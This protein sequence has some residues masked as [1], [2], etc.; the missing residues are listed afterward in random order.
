[1]RTP[2]TPLR[3]IG[4][5]EG[6]TLEMLMT[7]PTYVITWGN[8]MSGMVVYSYPSAA[9]AHEALNKAVA[10]IDK[11]AYIITR[12]EDISFNGRLLVDVFNRLTESGVN[13]FASR[14]VGTRRLYSVLST[15]AQP[16][17]QPEESKMNDEYE[18]NQSE[19]ALLPE[20]FGETTP[21][22]ADG[23]SVR[24]EEGTK[25]PRSKKAAPATQPEEKAKRVQSQFPINSKIAQLMRDR[26]YK[27]TAA[28]EEETTYSREGSPAITVKPWAHWSLTIGDELK[29]G[30]GATKLA[31]L[32]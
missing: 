1:M 9:A 30:K 18:V 4:A 19:P 26:G 24:E 23:N 22:Q 15:L 31:E 11:T 13:R 14:E 2:I 7:T 3:P 6:R 29:E 8:D 32:A 5:A 28:S 25:K 27:I 17:P 20:A 10:Y 21:E 12:E 16:G